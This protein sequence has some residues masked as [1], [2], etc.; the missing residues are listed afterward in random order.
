MSNSSTELL[1]HWFK[2][3][4]VNP[5]V[6]RFALDP[7]A[8]VVGTEELPAEARIGIYA[9]G[10]MLRLLDC[11]QADLPALHA[12]LGEDLF[13]MFAR[14]YLLE[15]PSTSYSLFELSRGFADFLDRTRPR[16]ADI[17]YD[18]PAELARVERGRLEAMRSKGTEDAPQ[19]QVPHAFAFFSGED[20]LLQPHP[21]LQ[22]LQLKM[23]LADFYRK[24]VCDEKPEL[25]QAAETFMAISRVRYRLR[26]VEI[27]A[28]QFRLLQTLQKDVQA[29]PM[30]ALLREV[31]EAT[32]IALPQLLADA[33]LWLPSAIEGGLL[34]V[35]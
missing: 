34:A 12:Y 9:R 23:P 4:L 26:M 20:T 17:A 18:L 6:R 28:W 14:A 21:C 10:Y 5:G 33:S 27:E 16:N 3:V 11:M 2:T 25:P 31:S 35:G 24:L 7:G 15:Q 29:K 13:V 1:Q 30:S 22:L 8:A 32:D 19:S